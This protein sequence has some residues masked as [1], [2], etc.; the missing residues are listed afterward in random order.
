MSMIN[1]DWLA[2]YVFQ[3]AYCVLSYIA[4][5]GKLKQGKTK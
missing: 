2:Q 3:T 4:E 5:A 1:L